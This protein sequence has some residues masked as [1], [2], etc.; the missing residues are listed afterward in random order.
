MMVPIISSNII[1]P[2]SV[3]V[4]WI[5]G[6]IYLL[7]KSIARIDVFTSNGQNRTNLITSNLF[8]P[9]SIVLDPL[10]GFLFF[11]DS[12]NVLISKL[13]PAKIERGRLDFYFLINF[14]NPMLHL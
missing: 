8:A 4:D 1:G 14:L 9:T 6:N 10:Q 3:A 12:G 2:F 13:Q 5:T 7:E 11:T